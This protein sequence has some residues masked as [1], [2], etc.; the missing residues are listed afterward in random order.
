MDVLSPQEFINFRNDFQ[1]W[2]AELDSQKKYLAESYRVD[3][4]T[5]NFVSV[6][7]LNP[8]LFIDDWQ[9]NITRTA[10]TKNYRMSANGGSDK[11]NYSASVSYLDREGIIKTSGL[12]R[13]TVNLN[14]TQK[15]N[16]R[17]RTGVN[18]NIGYTLKSGV[19]TAST[20]NNQGRAG[21]V[22]SAV[23]YSPVMPIRHQ[24]NEET[25]ASLGIV[26]DD[27][28]RMVANQ[29]GDIV[30]PEI[31]LSEN[32]NNGTVFQGSFNTFLEYKILEGLTF[33]S[34]IRG[35][36]SDNK[37]KA[38]FTDKAGWGKAY[39][40]IAITSFG[41][42]TS[43]VT[44]QNLNFRKTFGEHS[45]NAVLVAERQQN[46]FEYLQTTSNGFELP[47]LN[48]DAL[49]SALET[50]PTSSSATSSTLESYLAR[51]QYDAFDKYLLTVSA[52]YDGSSRFAD[53][54]KWG[55]FPSVGVAWRI[56]NE[57]FLENNK[58]ISNLKVRA[59]YGETGNTEIG[60]YL[61]LARA[62]LSS[63]IFDGSSL[64]T[65]AAI[66]RLPNSDLTW[67]TT[68][69]TDIGL[70]LGFFDNN[71]NIEADYYSKETSDLLLQVPLPVTSGY[72]TAF[73]NLGVVSNKGYELAIN[74]TL[75][76]K[77]DFSWNANFNISF[78]E[79]KIIDLGGADEFFVTAIG[80]SGIQ[81]DYV[82]R[83]GESIGSI[84][85]LQ[86][87]G[88]Y[89]FS[90]FEEFDGMTDAQAAELL[91]ANV[92]DTEN[93]YSV[94]IYNLKEGV[95]KNTKVA[96]GTYRPGM[97]KFIDKNDDGK[98]N[99]EDRHI[100]GNTQPKHFGGF[101]NNLT[102]K[103]F[104]LS[105]QTAWSYGNDIYNK[106][107]KKGSST[108]SP[109]GN[110]LALVNERW[111]P[112]NPTNT[113]TSFNTGASGNFSSAAYSRYIEDGSYFRLS[114]ITIG[115]KLSKKASKSVGLRSLRFYGAV[116]NVHVWTNY[117][118]WDP[119]VSVGR[120]QLTPGLDIDSYPRSRTFRIGL[121]AKF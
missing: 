38:Y 101:T 12:E 80:G 117:S 36:V 43:I 99:D 68:T 57:K 16:D 70:S 93:W 75:I 47:G 82:V 22:T 67:E 94:N 33:K 83:V 72:K 104:D 79:N 115:Y 65:G 63:Y 121:N 98:I 11:T 61:S 112:E 25:S 1:P 46:K 58:Y 39:G 24:D 34:S 76:D 109:W 37:T 9:D 8:N 113:L 10:L 51:V 74:A 42:S 2:S 30:N 110:K 87:D 20:N 29:N 92:T 5:G 64:N 50:L 119:D 31:M 91:Y 96:D 107:I 62:G 26:Y 3:D 73:K 97:T 27:E 55:F 23:L 49:G 114:N 88:V 44:E 85:G 19:V 103:G 100:I 14:V 120:N 105:I 28:G 40:G 77:D 15:I 21:V 111:S 18:A 89:T 102:Y 35:F 81:S 48:L 108:S 53:G 69:Q 78:N 41:A 66:D 4:G 32:K 13:Y 86:D 118:G 56:S 106:N 71:L 54:N 84:Y 59:S 6:S 60:S 45:V 7:A 90:D 52:R 17:L 116:D 95:V